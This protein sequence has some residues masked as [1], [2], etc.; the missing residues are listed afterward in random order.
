MT[1]PDPDEWSLDD[2]IE[3]WIQKRK[4]DST[5]QTVRGYS[6][7]L[8]Q[9]QGWCDDHGVAT[10]GNLD[11]WTLD[12]YQIDLNSEGYAPTTIKGRLNTLR[13]FI[14]WL[15]VQGMVDDSL[16]DAI[17]IPNLTKREE[18]NEERLES[19]HA[20]AALAYFRESTEQYATPMHAF[21]EVAWHTGARVSALR[22]LDL[23]DYHDDRQA[24]EF[25]HRPATDT[26]LKNKHEGERWVGLSSDVC[27]VLQFYIAR[28][29]S[30]RAD[31][32]GRDALFAGRQG[33]PSLT[34]LQAWSYQATQ[35]CLWMECP[36]SKRRQT[37]QWTQRSHASKC[38]SSRSP[39][40]IR[41]GSITWQ[42][43]MGV[44]IEVV[45][46]RVN[47]SIAVIKQYY[48]QADPEEAF[49]RRRQT[50][51]GDLDINR[52]ETEQ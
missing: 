16:P 43:N 45:A 32:H 26:P 37:C 46:E 40:T 19:D 35:P 10:V 4:S 52:T 21:L 20:K 7:R 51:A 33:R 49:E 41:T 14:E 13:L 3:R 24:V 1:R 11:A 36:H 5:E 9:W 42:L 15:V 28:E 30:D 39:H 8:A 25:R 22:G 23:S 47:A 38:P 31:E 12:Q 48:D 2:A 44:P 50:T 27:D 18:Q 29:R 34:T 6:S 17:D